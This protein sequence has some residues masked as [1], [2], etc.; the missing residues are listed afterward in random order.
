MWYCY[1]HSMTIV[2]VFLEAVK[3][4]QGDPLAKDGQDRKIRA[5]QAQGRRSHYVEND[6]KKTRTSQVPA[7]QSTRSD[8][9]SRE[10]P[11][12]APAARAA[13]IRS[14]GGPQKESSEDLAKR[15]GR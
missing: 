6:S 10:S 9:G 2:Q 5:R 15:I 8:G 13:A 1:T 12:A 3:C 4:Y 14:K 7:R 11:E